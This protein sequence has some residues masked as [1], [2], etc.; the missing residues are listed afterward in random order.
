MLKPI[1]TAAGLGD[2]PYKWT[3]NVS[4][5][6]HNVLKEEVGNET[7][8]VASFLERAKSRVFDAQEQEMVRG[9]RGIG[10]LRLIDSKKHQSI[11]PTKWSGMTPQQ[12]KMAIDKILHLGDK[13]DMEQ[14]APISSILS[15]TYEEMCNKVSRPAYI[16]KKIYCKADFIRSHYQ[17]Q[18]LFSGNFCVPDIDNAQTVIPKGNYHLCCSC[19]SFTNL[20]LCSHTVAVADNKGFLNDYLTNAEIKIQY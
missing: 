12:R 9:M 8:D 5:C 11:E 19:V 6:L 1:R 17:I 13:A 15:V 7:L 20:N 3:N 2:P 4:E 16:L 14:E 10:E 18:Q